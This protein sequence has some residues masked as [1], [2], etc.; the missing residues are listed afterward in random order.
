[1]QIAKD[2]SQEPLGNLQSKQDPH[3]DVVVH[4][5]EGFRPISKKVDHSSG[6]VWIVSL[7]EDEVNYGDQSMG[8]GCS[9]DS[10]LTR[11]IVL[12]HIVKES[13]DLW[14]TSEK[15]SLK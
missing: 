12:D 8:A 9:W 4:F 5:V 1:M 3:D 6:L 7:L 14:S 2:Q 10:K 13:F 11:I 15:K